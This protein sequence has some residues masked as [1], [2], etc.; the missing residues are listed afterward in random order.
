MIALAGG[1]DHSIHRSIYNE[2][3]N[4]EHLAKNQR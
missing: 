1:E 4:A 3:I 2:V